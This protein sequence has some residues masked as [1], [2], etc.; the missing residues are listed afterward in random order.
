MSIKT[1][2]MKFQ[3]AADDRVSAQVAVT[4]GGTQVFSGPLAD[5]TDALISG[6]IHWY[7]EPYSLVEFDLDVPDLPNPPGS[8]TQPGQW[9]IPYDVVISATGGSVALQITD[10]NYTITWQEV[11][12]ATDPA[13]WTQIPGAVDIFSNCNF[14]TQ[15]VWTPPAVN[16]MDIADNVGTPGVL[17]L[18]DNESVAYQVAMPYYSN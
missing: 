7:T 8:Q 1:V 4:V 2:Q 18:L 13:T 11:V 16:R 15:P 14:Q 17:I 10:A 5:T 12:P 6:D 3:V 9:T